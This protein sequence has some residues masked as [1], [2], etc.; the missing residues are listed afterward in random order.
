MIIQIE[1][2]S[3]FSELIIELKRRYD[4][5]RDAYP[6]DWIVREGGRYDN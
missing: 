4:N 5:E 6:Q 3:Y 1:E 2:P